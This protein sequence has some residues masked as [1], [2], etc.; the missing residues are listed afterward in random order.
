MAC[1][2]NEGHAGPCGVDCLVHDYFAIPANREAGDGKQQHFLVAVRHSEMPVNT[3]WFWVMQAIEEKEEKLAATIKACEYCLDMLNQKAGE[4]T[5]AERLGGIGG[6]RA[7]RLLE[8]ALT[9]A[10]PQQP[11][12]S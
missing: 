12:T 11:Q 9:V 5:V 6:V 2:V 8:D 3:Q 4:E 10:N 1:E 7:K